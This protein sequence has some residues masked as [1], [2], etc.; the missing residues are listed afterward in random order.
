MDRDVD[1]EVAVVGVGKRCSR[2]GTVVID[3]GGQM[4]DGRGTRGHRREVNGLPDACL[5]GEGGVDGLT[6]GVEIADAAG[7]TSNAP[8]EN[9]DAPLALVVE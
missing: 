3:A 6:V 1:G 5:K 9:V 7:V 8:F 2:V 4:L